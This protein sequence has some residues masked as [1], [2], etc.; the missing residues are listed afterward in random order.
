MIF[1]SSKIIKNISCKFIAR[2]SPSYFKFIIKFFFI[3]S[4]TSPIFRIMVL[5]APRFREDLSA[6]RKGIEDIDFIDVPNR[7]VEIINAVSQRAF[8]FDEDRIEYQAHFWGELSTI[9]NSKGFIATSPYYNRNRLIELASKKANLFFVAI[10]R[11]GTGRDSLFLSKYWSSEVVDRWRRFEG[12][13]MLLSTFT[14][15]NILE[16]RGYCPNIKKVVVG[17]PRVDELQQWSLGPDRAPGCDRIIFFSFFPGTQSKSDQRK[18]FDSNSLTLP[19]FKSF[20]SVAARLAIDNPSKEV[21]IKLKWYEGEYKRFLDTAVIDAV[22]IR[23]E[24]IDNL[25]IIGEF[26]AIELIK[27]SSAAVGFTSTA[28]IESAVRKIP[29]IITDYM[30]P[31]DL[32]R[33]YANYRSSF[34]SAGSEN[35]LYFLC[36]M[37]LN[38]QLKPKEIDSRLIR[39]LIGYYDGR[40]VARIREELI[41]LTSVHA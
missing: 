41:K 6:Y 4:E 13:L 37:A 9:I 19:L 11:E 30:Q 3:R 34:Y 15:K 2:I 32:S 5:D 39:E 7:L 1:F 8:S 25:K 33:P 14:V 29:V 26:S 35:D 12:D 38:G 28:L 27:K 20:H 24:E 23:P 21:I 31:G 22:G 16:D 17:V 10:F 18:F 36:E 40:A